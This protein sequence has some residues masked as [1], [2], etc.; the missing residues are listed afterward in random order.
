[1]KVR[2]KVEGDFLVRDSE[3]KV[4]ES[5]SESRGGFPGARQRE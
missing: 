5:E 1:M 2:V 4:S 3:S